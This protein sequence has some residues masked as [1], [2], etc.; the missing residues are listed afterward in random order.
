MVE[1]DSLPPSHP[2]VLMGGALKEAN[3]LRWTMAERQTVL[4]VAERQRVL[5]VVERQRVLMVVERQRILM[6]VGN[7]HARAVEED[8]TV[9]GNLHARTVEE[10]LPLRD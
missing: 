10:D 7:L 1:H 3:L 4:T 5:M 6:V 9:V 2:A 8:S